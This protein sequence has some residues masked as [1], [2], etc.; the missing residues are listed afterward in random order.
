MAE[1]VTL[2]RGISRQTLDPTGIKVNPN[3]KDEIAMRKFWIKR[4]RLSKKSRVD[5]RLGT[6]LRGFKI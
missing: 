4:M 6:S 2:A 1:S 5:A 3:V